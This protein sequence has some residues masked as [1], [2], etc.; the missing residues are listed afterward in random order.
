M[1]SFSDTELELA[2]QLTEPLGIDVS[3]ARKKAKGKDERQPDLFAFEDEAALAETVLSEE[4]S[5]PHAWVETSTLPTSAVPRAPLRR[6]FWPIRSR[7]AKLL[8]DFLGRTRAPEMAQWDFRY[9][10]LR[11]RHSGLL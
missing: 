11:P 3:K 5:A 8:Q 1:V 6:H 2:R 9:E 7:R 4:E 10:D